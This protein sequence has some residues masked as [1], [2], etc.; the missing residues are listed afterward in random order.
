MSYLLFKHE[1]LANLVPAHQ[2]KTK[3]SRIIADAYTSLVLRHYEVMTG[4]GR[5]ILAPTRT[6]ILRNGLQSLYD[7]NR[8][9]GNQKVNIFEQMAPAF[10]SYW[11]GMPIIGPLGYA[12][13]RYTGLFK[14]PSIPGNSDYTVWIN[15]FCAVIAAHIMTLGGIYRNYFLKRD[16][17]WSGTM[18]LACPIRN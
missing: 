12:N 13:V 1:L 9:Y 15:V 8:R 6:G 2:S 14:G 5:A 10:Y 11:A 16:F 17:E 7:V 4:G 18:M 3:Q